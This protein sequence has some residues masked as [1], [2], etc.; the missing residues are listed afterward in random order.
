MYKN[1]K[2][3][4][5][6]VLT[7]LL[8][9]L[10]LVST[11]H[12]TDEKKP[13]LRTCQASEPLRAIQLFDLNFPDYQSFDIFFSKLRQNGFNT[14]IIRVFQ[15]VPEKSDGKGV[16]GVFFK[17]ETAP[18]VRDLLSD[19][20]KAAQNN[21]LRIFAWMT[22]RHCDW[23]KRAHPQWCDRHFNLQTRQEEYYGRLDIF[24]PDFRHSLAQLYR[25][26]A[27]YPIDGILFQDDLVL[28]HTD[29]FSP[30]AKLAYYRET[31]HVVDEKKFYRET[32]ERGSRVFVTKY[33]NE[34]LLW[35]RW[36]IE[37]VLDFIEML[38]QACHEVN[39]SLSMA[40]NFYYE[41]LTSPELAKTWY[42]QDIEAARKKPIDVFSFM[43]YHRQIAEEMNL[44]YQ[45]S[46]QTLSEMTRT[47][48][49]FVKDPEKILMKIQVRDW[50]TS[51][52]IDGDEVIQ[53]MRS[54]S[55]EN[56]VGI[57]LVPYTGALQL[58]VIKNEF[59][60]KTDH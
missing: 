30:F 1:G 14:I 55:R 34:F 49:E 32:V 10:L 53:A 35:R 25:E 6:T 45:R 59:P 21:D 13:V 9:F 11:L 44:S 2:D 23:F 48:S 54:I 42:S 31:Y 4:K 60:N 22:S 27:R 56:A 43:A 7:L 12:A 57:A 17:S 46:L 52:P 24:N 16:T 8:L 18:V 5:K 19:A 40:V 20:C 36:K 3:C 15:N 51:K 47:A 41:T 50:T 38:Q 28:R 37:K 39:P 26:L 33:G 29:G 58:S